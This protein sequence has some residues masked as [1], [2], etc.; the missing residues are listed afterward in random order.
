M[1]IL[2]ADPGLLNPE[3]SVIRAVLDRAPPF[4]EKTAAA[5]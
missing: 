2:E 4:T 5:G 1:A 3:A